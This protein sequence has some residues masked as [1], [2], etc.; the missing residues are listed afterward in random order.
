[1]IAEFHAVIPDIKSAVNLH[2][3]GA[4][5]IKLEV[6][7]EDQAEVLKFWAYG[8]ERLLKIGVEDADG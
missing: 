7:A 8:K 5:T 6:S 4:A 1:M 2:G 3:D